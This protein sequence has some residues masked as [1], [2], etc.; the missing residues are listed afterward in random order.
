MIHAGDMLENPITGERLLFRKTSSDTGGEAVVLETFVKPDG[1]V[2]A[3]HVHPYQEERFEIL[4][5]SVGFRLGGR[6]SSRV[7]ARGSPSRRGSL[8]AS[9]TR[10]RRKPISC[11]RCVR[12][13]SSSSS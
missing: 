9:G 4:K 5:D 8:T 3:A 13:C 2:A 1:F 10:A 11:A 6:S 12:R 7:P